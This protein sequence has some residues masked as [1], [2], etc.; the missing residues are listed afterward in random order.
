MD[1]VAE[2]VLKIRL[3]DRLNP[4]DAAGGRGLLTVGFESKRY[5]DELEHHKNQPQHV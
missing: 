3:M 5:F 2:D 1:K 4:P